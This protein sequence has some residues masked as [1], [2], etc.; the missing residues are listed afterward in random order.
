ML[1]HILDCGMGFWERVGHCQ[2]HAVINEADGSLM[3]V[4]KGGIVEH[5]KVIE[6]GQP[7]AVLLVMSIGGDM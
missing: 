1:H 5:I 4:D 7:W 3:S 2:V 6:R